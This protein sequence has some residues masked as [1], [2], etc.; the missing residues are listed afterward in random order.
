[1]QQE[2]TLAWALG[3]NRR[4]NAGVSSPPSSCI[5]VNLLSLGPGLFLWEITVVPNGGTSASAWDG[6]MRP[7][8]I[9]CP[10]SP[11]ETR[12]LPVREEGS[13]PRPFPSPWLYLVALNLTFKVGLDQETL[14]AASVECV[15]L[16]LPDTHPSVSRGKICQYPNS[17]DDVSQNN[18]FCAL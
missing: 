13:Q 3:Q 6:F 2:C 11:C 17:R 16:I 9:H 18:G 14:Y 1:M 4:A 8:V 10:L 5:R 7:S 15:C 12:I